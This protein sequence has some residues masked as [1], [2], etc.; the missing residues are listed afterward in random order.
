MLELIGTCY[1][2]AL[3]NQL[4]YV[5]LLLFLV[6][7]NIIPKAVQL[8]VEW[9]PIKEKQ[10]YIGLRVSIDKKFARK[11]KRLEF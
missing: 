5:F 9:F 3:S 1:L 2:W 11:V 10:K 6:A 4:F 8:C 7:P